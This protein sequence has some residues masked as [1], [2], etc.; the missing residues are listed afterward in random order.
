[1]I[2][3]NDEFANGRSHSRRLLN[4]LRSDAAGPYT[5]GAYYERDI[6]SGI[7]P[8]QRALAKALSVS[9]SHV[10]RCIAVSQLSGTVVAAFGSSEKIS[11]RLGSQLLSIRE[12][13]GAAEMDRRAII[14][15]VFQLASVEEVLHVLTTGIEPFQRHP[16]LWIS[17]D[18]EKTLRIQGP[19]AFKL[20]PHR[21]GLEVA[22]KAFLIDVS[23]RKAQQRKARAKKA[24]RARVLHGR[25]DSGNS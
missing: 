7:W 17:V 21:G 15:S 20:I 3:T 4:S 24:R 9:V 19:D 23:E 11:F 12:A 14:A 10:S 8:S 1:M 6:R 13:I 18:D 22:I 25:G 5:L 2:E 16:N